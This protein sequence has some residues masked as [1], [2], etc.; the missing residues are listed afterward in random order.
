[1]AAA[2][3]PLILG[4]VFMATVNPDTRVGLSGMISGFVNRHWARHHYRRWY[5][6]NFAPGVA[7]AAR[8]ANAAPAQPRP[9]VT[10]HRPSL[11]GLAAASWPPLRHAAVGTGLAAGQR[12]DADIAGAPA[13]AGSAGQGG[14]LRE[15]EVDDPSLMADDNETPAARWPQVRQQARRATIARIV[16]PNRPVLGTGSLV[17]E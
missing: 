5:D 15:L 8:A 13:I 11:G 9:V 14:I 4:H 10:L 7:R 1:M 16:P 2:A 6:E 12:A 17:R 3:T